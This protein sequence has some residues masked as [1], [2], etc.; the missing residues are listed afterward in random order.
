M[1]R[2]FT[3]VVSL[4]SLEPVPEMPREKMPELSPEKQRLDPAKEI[5]LGFSKDQ[6]D[7]ESKRCLQCGIICYRRV[8]GTFH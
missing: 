5:A 3:H 8:K 6:A 2:T 7:K 4:D 1:I